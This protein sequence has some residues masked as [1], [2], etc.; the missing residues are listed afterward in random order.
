MYIHVLLNCILCLKCG[1]CEWKYVSLLLASEKSP[2]KEKSGDR[3]PRG[4]TGGG[5]GGLRDN[6]R[7]QGG[8]N[9]FGDRGSDNRPPRQIRNRGRLPSR[10]NQEGQ[11]GYVTLTTLVY[12]YNWLG[13]CEFILCGWDLQCSNSTKLGILY[14]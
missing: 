14:K 10:E 11:G 4:N 1:V 5:G 9:N 12:M 8:G 6:R 3:L 7:I 2:T 13:V